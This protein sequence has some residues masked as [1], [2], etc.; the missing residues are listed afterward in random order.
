MLTA[1]HVVEGQNVNDV[2][3]VLSDGTR[4][5]AVRIEMHPDRDAALVLIQRALPI[6]ELDGSALRFGDEVFAS[7]FSLEMQH[8]THGYVAEK[9]RCS[10]DVFPGMSGGGV[11]RNG[12]LVGVIEAVGVVTAPTPFGGIHIPVPFVHLFTP[13]ADILPWIRATLP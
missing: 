10:A 8:L 6:V 1:K 13:I 11:F 4:A 9:N 3:F 7:G 5:Q 2:T 12:K